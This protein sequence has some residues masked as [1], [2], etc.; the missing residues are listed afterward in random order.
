MKCV[1]ATVKTAALQQVHSL[2][3]STNCPGKC[4][5]PLHCVVIQ[6]ARSC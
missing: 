3:C 6:P 1:G 4:V 5:V 2:P